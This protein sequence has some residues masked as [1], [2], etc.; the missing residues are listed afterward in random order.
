MPTLDVI[1]NQGIKGS[2]MRIEDVAEKAGVSLRTLQRHKAGVTKNG[3]TEKDCMVALVEQG[4][5]SPEALPA[6]CHE[7]CPIGRAKEVYICKVPPK[8]AKRKPGILTGLLEKL[9]RK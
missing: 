1:I 7:R 8:C 5:I 2:G 4:V 9:L 3:Y 6:Y